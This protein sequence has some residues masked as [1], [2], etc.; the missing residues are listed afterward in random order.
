MEHA[1][2]QKHALPAQFPVAECAITTAWCGWTPIPDAAAARLVWP[3]FA[4]PLALPKPVRPWDTIAAPLATV[5]AARSIAAL[6][7]AARFAK[8]ARALFRKPY[9]QIKFARPKK[10][11]D[12][13]FATWRART[14]LT[15]I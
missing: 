10:F 12:A 11:R 4:N 15:I 14:G 9:R 3:A 2:N 13:K 7:P 1:P 6:A 8:T 5:V